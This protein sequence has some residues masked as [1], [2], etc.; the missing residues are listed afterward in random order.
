MP[1]EKYKR[2]VGYARGVIT[3]SVRSDFSF[4]SRESTGLSGQWESA[5]GSAL[6]KLSADAEL[7]AKE[8]WALEAII[9]PKGRPVV[10]VVR[11]EFE[12][13]PAPWTH[14]A[15]LRGGLKKMVLV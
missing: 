15:N 7:T 2:L 6:D 13:V 14:L 10:D 8:Q 9:L 11:D 4:G 1:N 5:A 3:E 12:D